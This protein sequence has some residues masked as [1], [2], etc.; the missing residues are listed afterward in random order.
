MQFIFSERLYDD[1]MLAL[2]EVRSPEAN[3][4][5]TAVNPSK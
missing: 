4:N 3:V 1:L 2:K 5:S